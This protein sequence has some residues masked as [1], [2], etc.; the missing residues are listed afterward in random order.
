[1]RY[2][3]MGCTPIRYTP[4]RCTPIRYRPVRHMP[5]RCTPVRHPLMRCTLVRCTPM[6]YTPTVV[7]PFWGGTYGGAGVAKGC[8][9]AAVFTLVR[10]DDVDSLHQTQ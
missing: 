5:V 2:T 6:R 1:M 8:P 7:W 3:P 9:R 4:M 10:D